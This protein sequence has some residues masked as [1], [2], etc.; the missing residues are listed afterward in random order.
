MQFRMSPD[1]RGYVLKLSARETYDWAHRPDCS[2]P[3]STL[4]DRRVVVEVDSNGLCDI[5]IDGKYPDESQDYDGHELDAIVSDHLPQEARHL[6]P[7]WEEKKG[8]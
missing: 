1:Q 4:S 3:C 2:W 6:W 5:A 8:S 7:T